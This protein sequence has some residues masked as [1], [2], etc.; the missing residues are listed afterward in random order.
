M[1]RNR[2]SDMRTRETAPEK[3]ARRRRRVGEKVKRVRWGKTWL[4]RERKEPPST[5]AYLLKRSKGT[6]HPLLKDKLKRKEGKVTA[7]TEQSP[8]GGVA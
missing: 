7:S 3:N 4:K 8:G 6:S 1:K 2:A 5:Q